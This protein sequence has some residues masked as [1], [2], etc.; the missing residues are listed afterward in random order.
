M[1]WPNSTNRGTALL[2][3]IHQAEQHPL[4]RDDFVGWFVDR[5]ESLSPAEILRSFSTPN[6]ARAAFDRIA[7]RYTILRERFF[8]DFIE[9]SMPA[10]FRQLLLLGAG[11]DTRSLRLA[12]LKEPSV[13]VVEVDTPATTCAKVKILEDHLGGLP[14][15]LR[16]IPLDFTADNLQSI[17]RRG[18]DGAEPT[19]CIWQGV[20][21]YLPQRTV[22]SV[23]DFTKHDLPPGSLLGFD[24]CTPLMLEEN[25]KIPGIKL[26][27]DRLKAIG[28]P[29]RFG[30]SPQEMEHL[31]AR[32]GFSDI[33]ILDQRGL[34]KEYL[35]SASMPAGMW[36]V[37]TARN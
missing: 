3:F 11:F 28:E 33:A 24:C 32:K 27:I 31:L 23:L 16:L 37:V 25:E 29:Y 18:L 13:R 34:E 14:P 36:Y 35:G 17:F 26:N 19:I 12:P 2:R 30:M 22:L 6:N 9:R 7:Y 21:Y 15:S 4:V 8:D 5:R 10:G 1:N 20:S